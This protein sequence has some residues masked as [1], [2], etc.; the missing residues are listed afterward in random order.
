[1]SENKVIYGIDLG[2]TYSCLAKMDPLTQQPKVIEDSINGSV[3]LPSAVAFPPDEEGVIVGAAAKE[4]AF[5]HPESVFQFFKRYMGRDNPDKPNYD[6]ETPAY[7]A[8]GKEYSPVDLSAIVLKWIK[9]YA[10]QSG[11]DLEDVIITV[12]AYFSLDQRAATKEAGQIAGLNVLATINEPTA[13]ALAFAHG[14]LPENRLM[15]VYDLGGGTFDVTLIRLTPTEGNGYQAEVI[16]TDGNFKLGGFDWDEVMFGILKQKLMEARGV[17]SEDEIDPEDLNEVR[18]VCEQVKQKLSNSENSKIKVAGERLEV[19]REEFNNA[20]A[21]LLQQTVD[22]MD[23][24]LSYSQEKFGITESQITDVLMVGG[25][26]RMEQVITMLNNRF[27][28]DR[29]R[30]NDPERAVAL[31]AA[32]A[33]EMISNSSIDPIDLTNTIDKLGLSKNTTIQIT[34]DGGIATSETGEQ[35]FITKQQLDEL[36][37]SDQHVGESVNLGEFI[38]QVAEESSSRGTITDVVPS[39]FGLIIVRSGQHMVD[40]V[41]LKGDKTGQTVSRKYATPGGDYTSLVL[42]VVQSDSQNA[43]NPAK[44]DGEDY[45]FPGSVDRHQVVGRLIIPVPAA[46]PENTEVDVDVSFDNLANLRILMRIPSY[47]LEKDL[48]VNFGTSKEEIAEKQREHQSLTFIDA[49]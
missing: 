43:E 24:M 35:T 30:F 8:R 46:L 22:L 7:S 13:A 12:P 15:L 33:G 4:I 45:S 41:I 31:G 18:G 23:A 39:T 3:S 21:S 49:T 32:V 28:E 19:S 20:T 2:T 29:V 37:L 26:T 48:E 14:T 42:P 16:A 1:M 34:D 10:S 36:G 47:G 25:S 40:N 11:E 5:E 6:P 9:R 38:E 27:G 17:F 44:R